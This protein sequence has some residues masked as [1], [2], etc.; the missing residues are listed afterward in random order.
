MAREI[1]NERG[2]MIQGSQV[3]TERPW[4][5]VTVDAANER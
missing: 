1:P 5:V 4:I 2:D 3:L